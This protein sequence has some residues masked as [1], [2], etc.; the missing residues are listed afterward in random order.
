MIVA[1]EAS[2]DAHAGAMIRELRE[3]K[4]GLEVFGVG[5]AALQAAGAELILDLSQAGVVGI[6]EL[7]PEL[8]NYYRAYRGLIER[9]KAEPLAG[10]I[11]L[12]LP[13]FNLFL[14][15]KIKRINPRTKIIYY[16][17]PQVW[18]WRPG[19]VKKIKSRADAMLVLFP[20]EV[21]I[22]QQAG[23]DVEFVGHPLKDAVKVGQDPKALRREFGLPE[24]GPVIALLPGSRKAEIKTYLPIMARFAE[25]LAGQSK[26]LSFVLALAPTLAQEEVGPFLD[27]AKDLIRIIPGR[28]DEVIGAADLA[29]VASGT[30]TLEAA[31]VGTPMI[32][33]GAVSGLTYLLVKPLMAISRYSLPNI[34]AGKE[35]VPE[36]IQRKVR[37]ERVLALAKDF[38]DNPE[39]MAQTRRELNKVRDALGPGGASRRAATAIYKRL[40]SQD[41]KSKKF[42]KE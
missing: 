26:N 15:K 32:V 13:D 22:Y 6:T 1:G 28:A 29:V 2:A 39:K 36:L 4:P 20:F 30:I 33:L 24:A 18:A 16:I 5:G 34:I 25:L 8:R 37:P 12:D 11:L 3:L 42:F 21:E 19:R 40:W 10:V 35:I 7:L 38:L 9:V 27:R 23:M 17:S 14:A 31:I 41:Q